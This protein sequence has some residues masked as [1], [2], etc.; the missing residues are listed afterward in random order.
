MATV[1]DISAPAS[2]LA[3]SSA[4]WKECSINVLCSFTAEPPDVALH[5]LKAALALQKGSARPSDPEPAPPRAPVV[6]RSKG[7]RAL[8]AATKPHVSSPLPQQLRGMTRLSFDPDGYPLYAVVAQLLCRT[9]AVGRYPQ[10]D[11]I[12][13]EAFEPRADIFRVFK[14]RQVLYNAVSADTVFLDVYERLIKNVICPFIKKEL[15]SVHDIEADS[16]YPRVSFHYQYPPSLRVQAGRSNVFGRVHRDLEYG[17]QEGEINFWMPLT[18]VRQTSTTLW[19]ESAPDLG[20]FSPLDVNYGEIAS[21]HGSLCHH[22]VPP[23]RSPHTRVSMDF[24]VGVGEHFDPKWELPGTMRTH[25][26][27]VVYL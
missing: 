6:R 25:G 12:V 20:D 18:D 14:E 27:R 21:F 23:N 2:P 7:E 19:A 4:I 16:E 24:R 13:L 17:H 9:T 8:E 15:Q 26:R 5:S 10:S 11:N 1:H 22:Y 3:D